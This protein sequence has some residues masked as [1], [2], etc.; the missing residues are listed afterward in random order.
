MVSEGISGV[1][2]RY[3]I[4]FDRVKTGQTGNFLVQCSMPD[5]WCCNNAGDF[6]DT[7][8]LINN[9]DEY[10]DILVNKQKQFLFNRSRKQINDDF[11][12]FIMPWFGIMEHSAFLGGEVRFASGTSWCE[13]ILDSYE[14]LDRIRFDPENQWLKL[15]RYSYQYLKDNSEG[16][17]HLSLRGTY[18]PMDLANALRGDSI[19]MEFLTEEENVHC[20]LTLSC[21][22]IISYLNMQLSVAD[23]IE[24]GHI[25]SHGIWLPENAVGFISEDLPCMCS[26]DIYRTFGMPYTNRILQHFSGGAIHSHTLGMHQIAE[27]SKLSSLF[28]LEISQDPNTKPLE[29][30]I[31]RLIGEIRGIPMFFATTS[32]FIEKHIDEM[33]EANMILRLKVESVD[34]GKRCVE[35]VRKYSKC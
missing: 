29:E 28:Y 35:L 24:G 7:A 11:I 6:L 4:F 15:L 21:E 33:K 31:I 16:I 22:M 19:L 13:H 12:P 32:S 10:L 18:G 9:P 3:K 5:D 1:I 25:S 27:Y 14:T 8:D 17:Y 34:E 20:L 2:D 30:S 23:E 26:P